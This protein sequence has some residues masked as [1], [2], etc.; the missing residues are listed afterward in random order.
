VCV[1]ILHLK[2]PI[3]LLKLNSHSDVHGMRLII[4]FSWR[5]RFFIFILG[6]IT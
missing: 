4:N 6:Y 3:D 5:E 2:S 1:F